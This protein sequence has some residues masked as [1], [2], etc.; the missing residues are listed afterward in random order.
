MAE[1]V[2]VA[3]PWGTAAQRAFDN[4]RRPPNRA[5]RRR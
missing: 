5:D 1:A 2:L 4:R 3:Q